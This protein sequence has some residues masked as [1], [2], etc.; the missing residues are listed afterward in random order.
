MDS[1]Q[2]GGLTPPHNVPHD[3]DHHICA[4]APTVFTIPEHSELVILKNTLYVKWYS[5]SAT[6]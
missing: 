2:T 3:H 1:L 5:H 4:H 6:K